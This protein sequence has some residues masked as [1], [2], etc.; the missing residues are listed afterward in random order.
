MRVFTAE[1]F[2]QEEFSIHFDEAV[3]D[4]HNIQ[5]NPIKRDFGVFW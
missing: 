3:V 1:V 2:L 5:S 4:N